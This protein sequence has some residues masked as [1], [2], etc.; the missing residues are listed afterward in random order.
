MTRSNSTAQSHSPC[1]ELQVH[2]AYAVTSSTC[3]FDV[4]SSSSTTV[5]DRI[6]EESKPYQGIRAHASAPSK[7]IKANEK[8]NYIIASF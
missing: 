4:P 2:M 8:E 7:I 3:S 1:D 6:V 5:S